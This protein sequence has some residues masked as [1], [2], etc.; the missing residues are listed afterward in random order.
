MGVRARADMVRGGAPEITRGGAF[1]P[2]TPEAIEPVL[3]ILPMQ[4]HSAGAGFSAS[5]TSE[6]LHH[7]G[8]PV[9]DFWV[10]QTIK[11]ENG[12]LRAGIER[13]RGDFCITYSG[14]L[15]VA[16]KVFKNIFDRLGQGYAI[17]IKRPNS[18]R[19]IDRHDGD[20]IKRLLARGVFCLLNPSQQEI[21]IT[22]FV[23]IVLKSK[24]EAATTR[25]FISRR[26]TS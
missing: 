23:N 4:A 1:W 26:F 2:Q 9:Q 18:E 5:F 25:Q 3:G 14:D 12:Q 19:P 11:G 17:G 24:T 6:S 10:G 20:Q 22:S 21:P 16:S 7:N 15:A 8:P 13:Y